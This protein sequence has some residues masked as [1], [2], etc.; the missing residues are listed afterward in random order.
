MNCYIIETLFLFY[1]KY[2]YLLTIN[3]L[4]ISLTAM[5]LPPSSEERGGIEN[6]KKI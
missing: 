6:E 5:P 2:I 4:F 1:P 3:C